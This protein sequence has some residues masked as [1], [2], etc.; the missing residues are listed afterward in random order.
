MKQ[1][2]YPNFQNIEITMVVICILLLMAIIG[3]TVV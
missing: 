1:L 3:I 2:K